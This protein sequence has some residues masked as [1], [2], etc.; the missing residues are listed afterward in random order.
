MFMT[1]SA[2]MWSLVLM[3][4]LAL[5]VVNL[6]ESLGAFSHVALAGLSGL[7]AWLLLVYVIARKKETSHV[8]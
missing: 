5:T 1:S 7:V 2:R 4:V 8:V 3:L 6:P